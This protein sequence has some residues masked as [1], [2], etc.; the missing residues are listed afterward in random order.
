MLTRSRLCCLC[1]SP[2]WVIGWACCHCDCCC[3]GSPL[4]FAWPLL[5]LLLLPSTAV[6]TAS[7]ESDRLADLAA[8]FDAV[9]A[10]DAELLEVESADAAFHHGRAFRP[11]ITDTTTVKTM[12]VPAVRPAAP[13][14][15]RAQRKYRG[16]R[17]WD[18]VLDPTTISAIDLPLIQELHHRVDY[19]IEPQAATLN[20]AQ[21]ALESSIKQ[22]VDATNHHLA[23]YDFAEKHKGELLVPQY[24]QGQSDWMRAEDASVR[25][26]AFRLDAARLTCA[27]CVLSLFPP[28]CR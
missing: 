10:P 15:Q 1:A 16:K 4:D 9:S 25:V 2:C 11:E 12:A 7:P 27:L 3:C 21:G 8:E 20:I 26:R 6:V 13:R 24:I 23:V 14:R 17:K 19:L 5:S 28:S 18:I 22:I